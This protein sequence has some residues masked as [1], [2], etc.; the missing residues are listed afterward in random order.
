MGHKRFERESYL[1]LNPE[2]LRNMSF[3]ELC[4][5]ELVVEKNLAFMD[6]IPEEQL[7]GQDRTAVK[8][9]RTVKTEISNEHSRREMEKSLS[10]A[11]GT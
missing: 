10:T 1:M 8:M 11:L 6:T 7:S 4:S 3:R 2:K 9:L 5:I